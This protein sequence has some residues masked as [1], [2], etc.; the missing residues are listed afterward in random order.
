MSEQIPNPD[1]NTTPPANPEA[2]A[3][4][5]PPTSPPP[6]A[7][8]GDWREQRRAERMARREARWQRRRGRPYGWFGGVILVLLGVIFLMQ[9]LGYPVLANWWAIFIL[10]PA[11]W[12]FVAAWNNYQDHG[13]FT[14]GAVSAL[15]IGVLFTLLAGIFLFNLAIGIFWP[16]LLIIGGLVILISAVFPT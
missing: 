12:A 5:P 13:R 8:P 15:T 1:A 10:I 4:P 16:I 9:S 11:F 2:D 3:T 14:R 7:P 6:A